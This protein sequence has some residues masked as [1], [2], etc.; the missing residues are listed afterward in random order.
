VNA[1]I[2]RCAGGAV[3]YADLSKAL[4][5]PSGQLLA[6]AYQSDKLHLGRGGYEKIS[7]AI[8]EKIQQ[9]LGQLLGPKTTRG[10]SSSGA[11]QCF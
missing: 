9:L 4:I 7:P 10:F 5:D 3:T 6:A 1:L 2:A 8:A 11:A